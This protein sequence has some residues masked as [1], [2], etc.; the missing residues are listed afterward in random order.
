MAQ[1]GWGAGVK[2]PAIPAE[3]ATM[4]AARARLGRVPYLLEGFTACSSLAWF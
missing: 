2:V 3:E 4:A 1:V